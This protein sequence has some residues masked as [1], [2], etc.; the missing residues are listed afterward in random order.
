[1]G[2]KI[3]IHIERNS[4][5]PGSF[6]WSGFQTQKVDWEHG[7]IFASL[8]LVPN[9]EELRFIWI[10]LKFINWHPQLNRVQAYTSTITSI[11][12]HVGDMRYVILDQGQW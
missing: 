10:Q 2:A 6:S 3:E 5:I 1:M 12:Q 7:K 4:Q 11:V 9:E 8:P